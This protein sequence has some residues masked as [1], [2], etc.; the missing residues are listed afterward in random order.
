[1]NERIPTYMPTSNRPHNMG[2]ALD[3]DASRLDAVQKVTGRATYGRDVYPKNMLVAAFIRSSVGKGTIRSSKVDDARRVEGVLE[4]ELSREETTY[5]GQNLGHI[6]AESRHALERAMRALDLRWTAERPD[7]AIGE[8]TLDA[9]PNFP[10]ADGVLEASYSTAVQTH[11]AL[12][13]HGCVVEHDGTKA[14]I[15]ASTQGTF[16]TRDGLDDAIGLDRANWEVKCEYVGG[17]FGSKLNGPGKEGLTAVQLAAK[18][19]R[20]IYF[21]VSRR[22]DHLDTGNRPS[23]RTLVNVAYKK[24]GTILG[25]EVRTFGAVGV[26]RG[27]G[28]VR[29]PSGRY[30]LGAINGQHEDVRTNAGA[31]RPFRAPG[32]PQG[33]FAEELML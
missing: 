25:G 2:A 32:W 17:G 24:D 22:E 27:G 23:S 12:E 14:T 18:Y 1:M 19:K 13:T 28:G 30:D 16:A 8:R 9:S 31:P 29:V 10:D 6:V 5:A 26:A 3:N 4:V 21:F 33:A 11:C 20:P 15:W 7:V